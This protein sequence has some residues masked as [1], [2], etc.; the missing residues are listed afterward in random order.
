[1]E[2]SIKLAIPKIFF[3]VLKYLS[4][5]HFEISRLSLNTNLDFK[6]L[7]AEGYKILFE[8][9]ENEIKKKKTMV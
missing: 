1:M 7:T 3:C 2:R 6:S 4:K 9:E 5:I 8:K